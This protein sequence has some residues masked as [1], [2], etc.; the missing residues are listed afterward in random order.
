M[1]IGR[2][3]SCHC[4]SEKKFKDCHGGMDGKKQLDL[5]RREMKEGG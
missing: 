1:K 3:D 4:G 2:N 5:I